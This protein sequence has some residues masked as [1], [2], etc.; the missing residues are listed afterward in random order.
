VCAPENIDERLLVAV[1]RLNV[2]IALTIQPELLGA[3]VDSLYPGQTELRLKDGSQLQ[4]IDS[5]ISVTSSGVKKFQYACLLRQERMVLVWQ[6]EV[7][8]ILT[9]ASRVEEKLLSYVRTPLVPV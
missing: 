1:Q 2:G 7:H 8:Q 4:I 6:D 3:I 5:L 9:H